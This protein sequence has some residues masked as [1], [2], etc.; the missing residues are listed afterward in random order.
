[1]LF[2]MPFGRHLLESP[3]IELEIN[4]ATVIANSLIDYLKNVSVPT[5]FCTL[6]AKFKRNP[7]SILLLLLIPFALGY[8]YHFTAML[9]KGVI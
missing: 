6:Y 3:P 7:V 5:I 8:L 9:T 2:A 1:M 4:R